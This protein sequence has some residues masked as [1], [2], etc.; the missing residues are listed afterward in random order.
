MDNMK[1][2]T[3]WRPTNMRR[4]LTKCSSYGDLA[5]GICVLL[6]LPGYKTWVR[7]LTSALIALRRT[8]WKTHA[9]ETCILFRDRAF[10]YAVGCQ[11]LTTE[12]RFNPRPVPVGSVADKVALGHMFLQVLELSPSVSSSSF[13]TTTLCRFSSSQPGL[14]KFFCP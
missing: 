3:Y 7:R 12:T 2:V 5:T 11:N 6:W 8:I 13:G 4:H 1:E 14:S 9:A 10:A